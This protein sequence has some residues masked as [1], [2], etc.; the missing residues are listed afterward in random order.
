MALVYVIASSIWIAVSDLIFSDFGG[1]AWISL[2]KGLLFVAVTG[3]LLYFLLHRM[4]I[5]LERSELTLQNSQDRFRWL[6]EAAPEGIFFQVNGRFQYVNPAAL[7]VFGASHRNQIE[8]TPILARVRRDAESRVRERLRDLRDAQVPN[9]AIEAPLIRLDG[10]EFEAELLVVRAELDGEQ[11]ELVFLRDTTERQRAHAERSR[12][13]SQVRQAQKMESI[14]RLAGAVAHDF[15]NY[16]TVINGYSQLLLVKLEAGNPLRQ[17]IDQIRLAGERAGALTRQLLSFSRRDDAEIVVFD[18]NGTLRG[19]EKILGRL[20]GE[21][22]RLEMELCPGECWIRA[23]SGWISQVVMNLVVNS[24]DAMP[25]GGRILVRTS[26]AHFDAGTEPNEAHCGDY[27]LIEV[28]DNGFGMNEE[29]RKHIFE[30][31]YT[32]KKPGEGTGLGLSTVYSI[33]KRCDGWIEVVSQPG[34]GCCFQIHLPLQKHVAPVAVQPEP[35]P[36]VVAVGDIVLLL[37]EDQDEVREFL[38]TSLRSNGFSVLTASGGEDALRVSAQFG[39]HIHLL[40]T[41]VVMPG[42]SGPELARRLLHLR[43]ETRVMF[44]SGYAAGLMDK[45]TAGFPFLPKPVETGTLARRVHEAIK[46]R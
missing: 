27:A 41:D 24:R 26:L 21:Q 34:E 29:T 3:L 46:G 14:G 31:F 32:T 44:M 18:L 5:R 39:G 36:P 38:A 16:L 43:P 37:A 4:Q 35:L 8:G 30:P 40:L 42:L 11:G 13:E 25:E 6:V 19:V 10:S 15:N 20:V 22:V 9:P 23:D 17:P 28:E 7:R 33:V 12:L 45:E 1:Y 2:V